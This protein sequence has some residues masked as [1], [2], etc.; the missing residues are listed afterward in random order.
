MGDRYEARLGLRRGEPVIPVPE[1]ET[2]SLSRC[3]LFD[4]VLSLIVCNVRR[5][6]GELR[7]GLRKTRRWC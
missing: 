1:P 2:G 3:R 6:I 4:G 5:L 7:C